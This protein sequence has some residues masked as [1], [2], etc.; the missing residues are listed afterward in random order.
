MVNLVRLLRREFRGLNF[1]WRRAIIHRAA[2]CHKEDWMVRLRDTIRG[3]TMA[4]FQSDTAELLTLALRADQRLLASGGL[5]ATGRPSEV[6]RAD[7]GACLGEPHQDGLQ[8]GVHGRWLVAL[9]WQHGRS[10]PVA[11]NTAWIHAAY[12]TSTWAV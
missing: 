11:S 1:S 3:Q 4:R 5:D 2:A 6:A 7:Y 12:A 9:Q 10:D 8:C